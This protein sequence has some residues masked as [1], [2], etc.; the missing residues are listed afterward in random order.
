VKNSQAVEK[1]PDA[2]RRA[3]RHPEAYSPYVEGCRKLAN[4]A[5]GPLSAAC[6]SRSMMVPIP[7][8]KPMHM[9]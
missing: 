7:C 9:V 6:Y 5:D 8:P 1:G 3:L 2:R 4:E